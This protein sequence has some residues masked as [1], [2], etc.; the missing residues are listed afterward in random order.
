[1]KNWSTVK[2]LFILFVCI[3]TQSAFAQSTDRILDVEN[4]K[5]TKLLIKLGK[6]NEA[7]INLEKELL[8][9]KKNEVIYYLL[10]KAYSGL[11]RNSQGLIY[12]KK[13]FFVKDLFHFAF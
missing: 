9:G 5:E 2:N 11:N 12:Y 8:K 4:Y 1:M 13:S 7:V 3:S 6:Y 10:G